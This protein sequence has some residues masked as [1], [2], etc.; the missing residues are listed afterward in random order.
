MG[1]SKKMLLAVNHSFDCFIATYLH[2]EEDESLIVLQEIHQHILC[3]M[4]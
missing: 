3:Y 1:N 4:R 2:Q